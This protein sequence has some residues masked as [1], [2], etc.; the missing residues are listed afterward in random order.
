ML[1]ITKP[2]KKNPKQ[3][4]NKDCVRLFQA[5]TKA[6]IDALFVPQH[7]PPRPAFAGVCVCV[8]EGATLCIVM[9][10][11]LD[12][13][14]FNCVCVI[15]ANPNVCFSVLYSSPAGESEKR[16]NHTKVRCEGCINVRVLEHTQ[17]FK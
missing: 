16:G 8:C 17:F 6:A 2:H 10:C 1:E 11:A 5:Q 14:R 4:E 9:L 7:P 12:T 15:R 13:I 3:C